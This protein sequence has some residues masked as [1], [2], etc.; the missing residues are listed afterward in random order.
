[1]T[2]EKVREYLT[3]YPDMDDVLEALEAAERERDELKL[4][5]RELNDLCNAD[6]KAVREAAEAEASGLRKALEQIASL[7]QDRTTI[8]KITAVQIAEAALSLK[9][10]EEEG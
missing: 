8:Y 4:K 1:M 9:P 6:I 7:K 2:P 3:K 10:A 5:G